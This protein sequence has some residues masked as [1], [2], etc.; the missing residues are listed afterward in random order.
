EARGKYLLARFSGGTLLV[1]HLGMAGS[2]HLYRS[3]SPWR[4]PAHLARVVLKCGDRVA[5]CFS[6]SR[7]ELID[8]RDEDRH[9]ALAGLGPDLV[10]PQVDLAS[11]VDRLQARAD[12]EIGVAL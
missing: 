11:A 12:E 6:P 1:T 7:V 10:S 8:A 2:W 3:G 5:V 9:P 4:R